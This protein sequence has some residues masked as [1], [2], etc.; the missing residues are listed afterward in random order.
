MATAS[1][2]STSD[3]DDD[4]GGDMDWYYRDD[5]TDVDHWDPRKTDREYFDYE[6]L[7]IEDVE[8]LLNESV[9]ALSAS[10]NISPSLAKVLLH[11]QQWKLQDVIDSFHKDPSRLLIDSRVKP[12]RSTAHGQP[13]AAGRFGGIECMAKDCN[14]LVP[15]DFVLDTVLKPEM[16]EKYQQYAFNDYVE[17]HP[18]LRF[19]PGPNCTVVARAKDLHARR[20]ICKQCKNSFCFRCGIDYHCPT[21]CDTIKRWIT[22]C[23]D[24]SETANYISAHTKDC[25]KCHI[26]IE[27]NGGCNHMQC[28]KC[29]HDFCWMCLGDWKTHGSEYYECSRFKENPNI[30]NETVHVQAREAL[31]K[32]LHYFE[33]CRYTLQYTYPYAYYMVNS[34]HRKELVERHLALYSLDATGVNASRPFISTSCYPRGVDFVYC[35]SLD[36]VD[37]CEDDIASVSASDVARAITCRLRGSC[38]CSCRHLEG[39]GTSTIYTSG[40]LQRDSQE[41]AHFSLSTRP[42]GG[43]ELVLHD[44][45]RIRECSS[46][47]LLDGT[48]PRNNSRRKQYEAHGGAS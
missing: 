13:A 47:C 32:Y 35:T 26:C 3:S 21:G 14:L 33:R 27:K 15:E 1:Q 25:P 41:S 22:K 20:V 9:E 7:Q 16:R 17:S 44:V 24:D 2:G 34:G 5:D 8:C 45:K 10:S 4:E 18:E 19:C 11:Q 29:K 48:H 37:M 46:W 28:S 36:L 38:P 12:S 31:K 40:V 43:F 30:A 39:P 6:L 23:A 42:H